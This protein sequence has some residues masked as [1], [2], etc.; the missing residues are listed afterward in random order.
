MCL[1]GLLQKLLGEVWL[2]CDLILQRLVCTIQ[3]QLQHWWQLPS[4]S[5]DVHGTCI[6]ADNL[7]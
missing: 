6:V 7:L 2:F 3:G 1:M 4:L 5:F